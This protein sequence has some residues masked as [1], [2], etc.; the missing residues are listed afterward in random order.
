MRPGAAPTTGQAEPATEDRLL[1]SE[2]GARLVVAEATAA[3]RVVGEP[4]KTAAASLAVAARSRE[5][6]SEL[7]G[8]LT[9]IV[10]TS[11]KSGRARRLYSA[12]GEKALN[13]VLLMTPAGREIQKGLAEVNAALRMLADRRLEAAR[14]AM[15][16]PGS[17]VVTLQCGG[18]TLALAVTADAVSVESLSV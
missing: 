3:S 10:A 9:N 17:F 14:V 11:L 2:E 13:E 1:L 8:A 6:P 12:E 4:F 18:A 15:R 7:F 16:V 5:V